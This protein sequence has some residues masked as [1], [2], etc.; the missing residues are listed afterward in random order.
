MTTRVSRLAPSP[1][2]ALHLGNARTFLVNWALAR[3]EGWRLLLRMEDL[4]GPRVRPEAAEGVLEVFRWLGIDGY[5]SVGNQSD[6]LEPYRDAMRRLAARGLVYPCALTRREIES[7]PRAPHVGEHELRF[8][9]ELRP[10]DGEPRAFD[11]EDTN[12]RLLVDPERLRIDDEFV[13]SSTHAPFDDVGDF[14]I[15]TRRGV[16]SYQLAVVVDDARQG[17]TD[18]VRGADLL[19]SAARQVLLYRALD[20]TPPRWWHLPLVIGTDGRRLAKRHGDTRLN[21]YRERGVPARR[22]IGLLAFWCGITPERGPLDP[23][24]FL[25]GLD[26]ARLSPDP[27]TFTADDHAWLLSETT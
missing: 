6:D 21:S 23:D 10:P 1:T 4:D 15:W 26:L 16:P 3:R 9:V 2:G 14:V 22:V 25:R 27:V 19:P 20:R 7:A 18:V 24:G 11:A 8:P 5:E 12:Y 17:V 13:G